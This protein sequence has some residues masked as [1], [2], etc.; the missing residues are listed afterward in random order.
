MASAYLHSEIKM[1]SNSRNALHTVVF[2][3]KSFLANHSVMIYTM[4]CK[5]V[6]EFANN[7]Y[8]CDSGKC[9]LEGRK[10]D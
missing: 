4:S 8:E 10:L 5:S 6:Y 1:V 3:F 2:R 7:H 9:D